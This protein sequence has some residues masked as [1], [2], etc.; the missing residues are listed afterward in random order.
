MPP[1]NPLIACDHCARL[2]ERLPI[3][4]GAVASCLQCGSELYRQ[5]RLSL[6]GWLALSWGALIVFIIANAFPVAQLSMQGK[7]VRTS[8][9]H[10]L[11]LTWLN[12]DYAVAIMT[13][14]FVVVFPLGQICFV[15][16]AVS[17]LKR[18]CL[19]PD[20]RYGLRMLEVLSHWSMVPVLLL[21]ALVSLVKMADLTRLEPAQGL[22]AFAMLTVLL[23]A[24][25]RMT[26][27]RL[28]RWAEDDG[29]VSR[30]G[31]DIQLS[32]PVAA[33]PAC[34]CV[35]NMPARQARHCQRCNAFFHFRRPNSRSNA[36]AFLIAAAILYVPANTLPVMSLRLPTGVQSHTIL[37]GVI[38]LWQL[39]SWDL[40]LVVF[41]ASIVVPLTKL[42]ALGV[43]LWRTAWRGKG[44]QRQRTRLYSLV[45][46]I[47]QWSMLDV[48][49]VVF[50]SSMADFPGLTQIIAGLG[51]TSFGLVVVLTMLA[52]MSYDPRQGWDAASHQL[53][54]KH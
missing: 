53:E 18:R 43:L 10:A 2:H 45:E 23:T 28:W 46:F 22:W 51:A 47:G 32:Q 26:A 3:K 31:A 35:Q 50:L 48:F 39:G 34:A 5:P 44:V 29:L 6:E 16:W 15:M 38:E 25:G 54:T 37:G 12:G 19:P 14:L 27:H 8:L 52:A 30:S 33:C 24:L 13:A 40:A 17:S 4:P 11:W 9:L 49:V 41:I 36:W 42:L 7:T 21:A 1:A 20:F